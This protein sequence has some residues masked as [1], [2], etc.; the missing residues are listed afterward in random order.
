MKKVKIK[1]SGTRILFYCGSGIG[2]AILQTPT[3][4][5]FLERPEFKVDILFRTK[6]MATV[7]KYDGR[8]NNCLILPKGRE[9]RKLFLKTLHGKYDSIITLFPSNRP[10]YNKIAYRTGTPDR[11]IHRYKT[12][13]FK[14]R[15]FLS[16]IKINLDESLHDV[17]QNLNLL[18]PFNIPIPENPKVTFST[19]PQNKKFADG[20]L[21]D[22]NIKDKKILGI[23]P[24]CNE[25]QTYK[26]WPLENY[27]QVARMAQEKGI[28]PLF[29][30]GPDDKSI[31]D[32][33]LAQ[34]RDI[35]HVEEADLNNVASIIEKCEMFLT[36]D[37]GLGHIAVAMDTKSF[38][39]TG[40]AHPTRTAPF[41]EL[42]VSIH[43]GLSC[44][45]CLMYPFKSTNSS[46]SCEYSGKEKY[47]CLADIKPEL[48]VSTILQ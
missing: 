45:P 18:Q 4:N 40:P 46:I 34:P 27:L 16:N 20:F 33:F 28:A 6:A 23:H 12:N 1:D 3:I 9:D 21:S 43:L 35:H 8:V 24:G 32:D 39:I 36:S 44:S 29:F 47:K 2:N 41:G 31:R 22:L 14:T 5:A 30:F 15:S 26:R 11:V 10:N 48:V 7:F 37:S 19:S 25:G 13:P 42:G 17:Y 38:A